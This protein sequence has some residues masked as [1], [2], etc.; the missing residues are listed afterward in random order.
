[1]LVS[2]DASMPADRVVNVALCVPA[3]Q[4][5]LVVSHVEE[6][7]VRVGATRVPRVDRD[8]SNFLV[9]RFLNVPE[10]VLGQPFEDL[11]GRRHRHI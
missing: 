8:L 6:V 1:M 2:S 10:D 5:I 9:H 4:P 3:S 11:L 7:L